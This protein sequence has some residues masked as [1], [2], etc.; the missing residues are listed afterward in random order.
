MTRTLGA[1]IALCGLLSTPLISLVVLATLAEAS[2]VYRIVMRHPRTDDAYLRA[3]FIGIAPH[4]SGP[5]VE[6]PIAEPKTSTATLSDTEGMRPTSGS[7]QPPTIIVMAANAP[8][9]ARLETPFDFRCC[10][11]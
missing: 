4:V 2:V 7:T 9:Q 1:L 5:I 8:R 10:E 3:N 11:T 6:L